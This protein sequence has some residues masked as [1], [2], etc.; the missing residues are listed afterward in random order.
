GEEVDPHGPGRGLPVRIIARCGVDAMNS[1]IAISKARTREWPSYH[2]SAVPLQSDAYS[3]GEEF[4]RAL[5]HRLCQPLTALSC[6]LELMQMGLEG[7]PRLTGQI[8]TAIMQSEKIS[9]MMGM[10]R[11][12]FEAGARSSGH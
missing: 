10:F 1:S 8:Q 3:V 6:A 12:M 11:Q 2:G 5:H 7:D 4:V 9:E